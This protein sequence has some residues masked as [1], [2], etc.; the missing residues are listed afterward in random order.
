MSQSVLKVFVD[1]YEKGLIY[2]GYRMVNWDP[3]AQT[4]LSDEEV[5]YKEKPGHLYHIEYPLVGE[6]TAVVIA[7]TRPET[8]LGDTAVCVHPEDERYTHLH[9]KS[10]TV[11]LTGRTV[12][13][14]TDTYVE[15]EFGTGCLK[16]TPAHDPND[17]ELGEKHQLEFIDIFNPDGTLNSAGL[18]YEGQ[19]RFAIRKAIGKELK[20]KGFLV[21]KEDYNH[22]VG[23]SE[24][25]K[26]VIEP[27]ISEQW[28]LN[29][30]I[31]PTCN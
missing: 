2:K 14:I 8:L 13:I 15:Q 4:T 25:T 3:E 5:I 11:P 9:G 19:D 31:G 23:T 20:E 30:A 27:R 26:A 29:G 28:F 21:K 6:D 18:H 12:P 22:K 16:V 17:K 24:R 10:V 1:L 7:T